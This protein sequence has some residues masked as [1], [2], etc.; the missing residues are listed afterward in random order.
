MF[1]MDCELQVQSNKILLVDDDPS[2]LLE[3][4]QVLE[5][6]GEV[7]TVNTGQD[8]LEL[9]HEL[10][11]DVIILD[12]E[13][14]GINGFEVC[15]QLR[16]NPVTRDIGIIF[17]TAHTELNNEVTSL[18]LG[19]ID[20]IHKPIQHKVCYLRVR[21][22]LLIRQQAKKL[23]QA[24]YEVLQ[25]VSQVPELISY[26][27]DDWHNLFSNDN[28]GRW[29][30]V[31]APKLLH[32]PLSM[33]LP[34]EVIESMLQCGPDATGSYHLTTAIALFDGAVRHY[35]LRWSQTNYND[36]R[37]GYLLT[38]SDITLQKEVERSLHQ[39]R[40]HLNVILRSVSEGV[41]ATDQQGL[42]TFINPKAE[43]MTGWREAD[44]MGQAIEV[45]MQLRDPDSKTNS[46]NP[47][48]ITLRQQRATSMPLNTQLVARD[49]RLSLI[50][51]S[52]SPLRDPKGYIVG[53]VAVMHDVSESINLSLLRNQAASYDPLTDIPNRLFIR[54]KLQLAAEAVRVSNITMALAVLDVDHF[55]SFNDAHGNKTGDAVLR[56]LAR[57]LFEH[58]EPIHSVG[59]LGA[60]EF[61]LILRGDI[62]ESNL[63]QQLEEFMKLLHQPLYVPGDD[64]FSLS[65]SVG[66]SVIHKNRSY[67][68][69]TIMQQ[70]DAAL[71]RAKFE[72][73]DRYKI[74]TQEL[75][76]SLLQRRSTEEL[77]RQSLVETDRVEVHYQPKIHFESG[78]V[79]G[80]EAL[81]RLRD[82][83]DRIISPSEFIP[84]AEETGL[85]IQLG[86]IVMEKACRACN[87]WLKQGIN[88]PVSVNISAVQCLSDDIV[89]LIENVLYGSGLPAEQLELEVTETSFIRDFDKTQA[90]FKQLRALGVKLSIDDFGKGY[91][92]LTY[93]RSMD[94]DKLKI[95][96]S[97]VRGM[98]SNQHD[99]EIVKTII[100]LGHSMSLELVAE[101]VES[102]NHEEALRK[103]GCM[104]GQ[105]FLYSRP[106]AL[107]HFNQY[108]REKSPLHVS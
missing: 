91:S 18:N 85:I 34:A 100:N 32:Q 93:L 62:N 10:L 9:T 40:E 64:Q 97:Y 48:R 3:L 16:Q 90:K 12:I 35:V 104:Q 102:T 42:V 56:S 36:Y 107:E 51:Q 71:Y 31:T 54:E 69:D 23:A 46:E 30:G 13:M 67:D 89:D 37:G 86:K 11:P 88:V 14:P 96:M 15:S 47:I 57:R 65:V 38:I 75:E 73:G 17:V 77:L 79:V 61:M 87:S 68:P 92:N 76:R 74:F 63:E 70:A 99:Y 95:D 80:C 2:S 27:T 26:W 22:L 58:Y 52:S 55:K 108:L 20:F 60:D 1:T 44:A 45:I 50:E 25:L 53:A 19:A 28:A 8:A 5:P 78:H 59:R 84:I 33:I 29:F 105:G 83:L 72:G 24:K 21:N 7:H 41:I 103:L 94:V 81:V 66:V 106:L 4:S 49:G 43:L 98:L 82:S 39:Q 101:G 6:L